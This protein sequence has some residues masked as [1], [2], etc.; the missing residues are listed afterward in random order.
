MSERNKFEFGFP[1]EET[2]KFTKE[3]IDKI[4]LFTGSLATGTKNAVESSTQSGIEAA[5]IISTNAKE[6]V[7]TA[8]YKALRKERE[9]GDIVDSDEPSEEN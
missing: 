8:L 3:A 4:V 9:L 5:N 6:L 1:T 2:M 7:Q